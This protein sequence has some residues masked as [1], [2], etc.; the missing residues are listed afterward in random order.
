M[1]Y[2]QN[3]SPS[4]PPE[5]LTSPESTTMRGNPNP[6]PGLDPISPE[7]NPLPFPT[8]PKPNPPPSL[9]RPQN[10]KLP[11]TSI[12]LIDG[13][14]NHRADWTKQLRRC[15]PAY[16]IVEASEGQSGLDL[17]RSRQIDCVVLELSLPDQSGFTVLGELVPLPKRPQV[18]VIVLTQ[19]P[20]RGVWEMATLSG[21]HACFYKPHTSGKDLDQAI[22]RAVVSV[23]QRLK[24]DNQARAT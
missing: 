2:R 20:H 4:D 12:L 10:S 19:I 22:Q 9:C 11:T 24:G 3:I 18:A 8:P 21:A 14:K 15:S 1:R 16:E 7:P 13:S 5:P 6:G 17:Y 23:S